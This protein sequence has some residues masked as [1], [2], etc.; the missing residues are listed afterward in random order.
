[1]ISSRVL[2]NACSPLCNTEAFFLSHI[3]ICGT[4]TRDRRFAERLQIEGYAMR[5]FARGIWTCAALYVAIGL[6]GIF[7]LTGQSTIVTSSEGYGV[8]AIAAPAVIR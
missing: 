2:Q 3:K 1:M 8:V 7:L 4:Q 5:N 6:I